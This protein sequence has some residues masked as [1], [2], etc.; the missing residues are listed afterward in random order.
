[1]ISKILLVAVTLALVFGSLGCGSTLGEKVITSIAGKYILQDNPNTYLEL[2]PDGTAYFRESG[3]TV[4]GNWKTDA[5]KIIVTLPMGFT[6]RGETKG[7]SIM[8]EN[9]RTWMKE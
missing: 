1:M 5:D 9:G 3:V 8:D 2:K 4:S 6:I 7:N